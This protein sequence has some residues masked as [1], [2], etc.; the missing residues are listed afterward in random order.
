VIAFVRWNATRDAH[1]ICVVNTSG[2]RK[3]RYRIGV[4]SPAAYHEILNTDS[5]AY[6]GGDVG[7]GG[8]VN[9]APQPAHGRLH[10]VEL[11]L[12]PLGALWLA[13]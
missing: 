1:V 12:P 10:S 2:L 8:V 13:S 5:R 9:A 11:T 7:N 6:G 3:D 4:P